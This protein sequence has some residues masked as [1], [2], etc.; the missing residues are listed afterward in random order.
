VPNCGTVFQLTPTGILTVLH[1]FDKT[2]GG[3]PKAALVQGTD[4]NFYGVTTGFAG[5]H[6]WGT[7][8]K[9]SMGLA[10][11]VKTVPTGAYPG[12]SL[13]SGEQSDGSDLGHLRRKSRRVHSRLGNGNH[14]HRSEGSVHG[15][16]PGR[17]A[18]R[19]T[20][21]QHPIPGFLILLQGARV[22][23]LRRVS[24]RVISE[25]A[26]LKPKDGLNGPS[27]HCRDG[28]SKIKA[29]PPA[30]TFGPALGEPLPA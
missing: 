13:Y 8:F 5:Q 21:E 1:S 26:P 18:Q 7:V 4:G 16:G 22:G 27:T 17:Y 12:T 19:Y 2:D 30:V 25:T 15:H 10:P 20:V 9:L 11:F 14:S 6:L 24:I 28:V 3:Y 29:W 23:E